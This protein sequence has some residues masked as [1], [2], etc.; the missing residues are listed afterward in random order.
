M[1]FESATGLWN[2]LDC[3]QSAFILSTK[4]Q[5]ATAT[6]APLDFQRSEAL[7]DF[8]S[9][10]SRQWTVWILRSGTPDNGET[11]DKKSDG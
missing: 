6:K 4:S 8:L 10:E 1:S 2:L 5:R 3:Y 9:I 11:T 7:H